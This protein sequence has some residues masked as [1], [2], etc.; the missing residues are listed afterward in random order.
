MCSDSWCCRD[1]LFQHP[2]ILAPTSLRA[3][4]DERSL[5]QRDARQSSR[6]HQYFLAVQNVRTQIDSS[7]L[8]MIIH[9]AGMLAELNHGLGDEIAWIGLNLLG[10]FVAFFL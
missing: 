6:H 3:V 8:K 7:S 10:E 2:G 4:H 9:E 1:L 5:A